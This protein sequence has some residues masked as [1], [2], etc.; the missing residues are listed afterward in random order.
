MACIEYESNQKNNKW[1]EVKLDLQKEK[2]ILKIFGVD[3]ETNVDVLLQHNLTLFDWI[4]KNQGF[5]YFI[6]KLSVYKESTPRKGWLCHVAAQDQNKGTVSLRISNQA[7]N[8]AVDLYSTVCPKRWL[9]WC[10]LVIFK[11]IN[12]LYNFH[13]FF[14]NLQAGYSHLKDKKW[15]RHMEI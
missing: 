7:D 13:R 9:K 2:D 8:S 4:R 3:T 5:P 12:F 14:N 6:A 15:E 11:T 10:Q 1:R